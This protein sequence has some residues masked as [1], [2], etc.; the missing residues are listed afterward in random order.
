MRWL[1]FIFFFFFFILQ[2]GW[3]FSSASDI[4]SNPNAV[5]LSTTSAVGDSLSSGFSSMADALATAARDPSAA[6]AGAASSAANWSPSAAFAAA[7]G[8]INGIGSSFGGSPRP[9]PITNE[10]YSSV[11]DLGKQVTSK[12]EMGI[13]LKSVG[14]CVGSSSLG[15]IH[16][17]ELLLFHYWA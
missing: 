11:Y 14:V 7:T 4:F 15:C 17:L 5:L 6:A 8:G 12:N 3:A 16:V 13:C 9:A 1:F 2:G 10:S